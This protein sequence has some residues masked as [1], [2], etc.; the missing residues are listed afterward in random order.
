MDK[1]G[2]A[3][4]GVVCSLVFLN[5]IIVYNLFVGPAE[6]RSVMNAG[7][8]DKVIEEMKLANIAVNQNMQVINGSGED[9]WIRVLVEI[10]EINGEKA[11]QLESDHI[12]KEPTQLEK[13][14]GAWVLNQDGFYYYSRTI[15]PGEQTTS[16]FKS[17]KQVIKTKGIIPDN[18]VVHIRAQAIQTGWVS[19]DVRDAAEAFEM[20]GVYH[21]LEEYVGE[22]L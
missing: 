22:V 8:S 9:M 2:K 10:P 5:T 4:L 13:E 17:I 6:E 16:V 7:L 15:P 18:E 12:H 14:E 21:P 20:F 1:L 19:E 11:Y 3:L